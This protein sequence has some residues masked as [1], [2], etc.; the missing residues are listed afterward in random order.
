MV[1]Q[2]L[3]QQII[4]HGYQDRV[5]T[6][7]QLDRILSGNNSRRY[8]LVN[9]ALK[10]GELLQIKRGLYVLPPH[11]RSQ[12]LHPFVAAQNLVPCSY[13][14]FE[15]A[16]SY[17]GWIPELAATVV[18]VKPG[19]K[20]LSY[21]VAWLGNFAFYPLALRKGYFLELVSR[22][23]LSGQSFLIASPGRA[24]LDLV[25]H[26][27]VTW[28]GVEWITEGLRIEPEYLYTM[29]SQEFD[30]LQKIYKH[31]RVMDFIDS[32]RVELAID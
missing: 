29:T 14:S 17:H 6:S 26:R 16:L 5:F 4:S 31:K 20:T 23:Q 11:L 13:I 32:M 10:S 18:S 25:C 22:V 1:M 9:R 3:T 21:G 30:D 15:T 28:R 2:P 12:P 8:G 27:K 7:Q 19:R 24:L